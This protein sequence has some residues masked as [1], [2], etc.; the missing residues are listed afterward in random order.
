MKKKIII[1]A[2]RERSDEL[3]ALSD[4]IWE[5]A[6][7]AY[8]EFK[9]AEDICSFLEREGFTV[10]RNVADIKTAFTGSFGSGKP[11][12]GILGEYDALFNL[13]Q[14]AGVAE[15][16]SDDPNAPGHG[17]GHNLLGVGSL[18]AAIAV[19]EYIKKTGC[20]GT[21]IYYGTPAEEG[22]SGKTFMARDGVFDCLDAAVTWHPSFQNYVYT[23]T[24]LANIQSHFT[25]K[26][27]ASHAAADPDR[28]RSALDALE[29]MN[30]GINFMREHVS[31]DARIHYS[32]TNTGGK[33]PN[34]VQPVA[35]GVYLCRSPKLKEAQKM[36]EWICD[37]A[38]GAALMTQTTV[39]I[40]FM[41]AA[42]NL[43]QNSVMEE[44]MQRNLELF[45]VP[46]LTEEDVSFAEEIAKTYKYNVASM[47]EAIRK[48]RG[49]KSYQA[50]ING[51]NDPLVDYVLPLS[52]NHG[53]AFGSS[54]VGDVSWVCP[55]AQ[56]FIATSSYLAPAHSWQRVAQGKCPFAHK[57][58]LFAGEIM[59]GAVVDLLTDP[60]TLEKAK[61]EHKER[62]GKDGYVCPIPKGVIPR[63]L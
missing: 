59:A 20:K 48:K 31:S 6:E 46:E 33:S 35:E 10:K 7:T 63:P 45:P 36:Y 24:N 54:D 57:G 37:I 16:C 43:L 39:E 41:K 18:A 12:I 56:V 55:T 8:L 51:R 25:F 32:I 23:T 15:V 42:S 40:D 62:V 50:F 11:V 29:L 9:S 60:E 2:I 22:G 21:V 19:K 44:V 13:N 28:G 58:M 52:E 14:K 30:V 1:D 27:I 61:A 5:Y 47:G 34:V 4:R 3:I 17:C 53:V 38:R 49:E 26:G